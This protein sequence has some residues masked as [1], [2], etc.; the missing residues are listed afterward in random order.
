MKKFLFH[1]LSLNK[2]PSLTVFTKII[3]LTIFASIFFVVIETEPLI[4]S[5]YQHLFFRINLFFGT[6]FIFEYILRLYA[7]GLDG[8]YSGFKGRLLYIFTPF[9]LID[10]LAILPA[11]IFPGSNES[12]LLRLFRILRIF[13]ILKASK[14]TE[15][16]RLIIKVFKSK[17]YELLYSL[18]IT[19]SLIFISAILLYLAEANA[20]PE[21]FGSI[22]R[23]LWW[24]VTTLT[25]VGYG[26]VYPLTAIGKALTVLITITGIGVV[27]IPTGILAGG[28]S[29]ILS[30]SKK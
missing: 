19:L 7:V 6:F 3:Y 28:F 8:R 13:S 2:N 12:F 9:S 20:Q 4:S 29:E 17:K 24:A 11:F 15:G 25:T 10:I 1:Q 22:P 30:K 27:A 16:L 26:D 23:S 18:L 14:N 21:V 5:N